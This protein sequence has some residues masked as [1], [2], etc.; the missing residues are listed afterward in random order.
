MYASS[1]SSSSLT[2]LPASQYFPE[3]GESRQ[4]IKFI[5][6][7]L[8]D[9]DG[10]MM[11]TYS[12]LR[13]STSTPRNACTCSAPISYTLA[14]DSVLITTPEPT[15]S[16]RYESVAGVSTGIRISLVFGCSSAL[17]IFRLLRCAVVHLHLSL[18]LQGA[19]CLVAADDNL[20]TGFQSLG[21][22]NIGHAGDAR[23][24]GQEH[25]LT[26]VNYE[27]AL[28]FILFGIARRRR[29]RRCQRHAGTALFLCILGR[30]FQILARRHRQCLDR[31]RNY[32]LLFR[33][34]D[35]GGGRQT[36]PQI[37]RGIGQRHDDFEILRFLR[38]RR[39]LRGGESGT[40]QH[41]L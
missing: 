26:S 36:G 5:S 35:L 9:P 27:Y 1:S 25:R 11:A 14:S 3:L 20:V 2:S 8:P 17:L 34:L 22:F 37:L 41:G 21:D 19:Q 40:A 31:N 18:R 28:H 39:G 38:T 33:R 29:R 30:F 16:S 23:L 15:R 32:V 6:V 13:I 10:P 12:P 4:P 24:D 7:D